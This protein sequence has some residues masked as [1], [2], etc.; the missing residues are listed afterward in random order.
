M[1]R[2]NNSD[3]CAHEDI[4]TISEKVDVYL[5][6]ITKIFFTL[7]DNTDSRLLQKLER[8]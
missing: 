5:F 6:L 7:L 4:L 3:N 2:E 8:T 1:V